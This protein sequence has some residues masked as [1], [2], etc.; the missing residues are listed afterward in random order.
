MP[1]QYI[2][3]F[4]GVALLESISR[5]NHL[6]IWEN[7]TFSISWY[8]FSI[9]TDIRLKS[10]ELRSSD[11]LTK[12]WYVYIQFILYLSGIW[13]MNV[14]LNDKLLIGITNQILIDKSLILLWQDFVATHQLHFVDPRVEHNY[15]VWMLT[16]FTPFYKI[17][18]K[19]MIIIVIILSHNLTSILHH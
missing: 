3:L 16:C 18:Q 8:N 5:N 14:I 12:D 17:S 15:T 11:L 6:P 1:F 19:F 2:F 7:P 10:K 13:F 4:S 9:V